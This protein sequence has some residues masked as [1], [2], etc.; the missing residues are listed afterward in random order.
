MDRV[1]VDTEF[2]RRARRGDNQGPLFDAI[3]RQSPNIALRIKAL[4]N[5]NLAK[6]LFTAIVRLKA[7]R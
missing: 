4:D 5:L 2:F 3:A 6:A 7:D 1:P